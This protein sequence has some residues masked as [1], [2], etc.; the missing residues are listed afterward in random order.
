MTLQVAN[1]VSK[2]YRLNILG[3]VCYERNSFEA[4]QPLC[5][6]SL[7][8][9]PDVVCRVVRYRSLKEQFAG[10]SC[11]SDALRQALA[12]EDSMTNASLYILL[13]AADRFSSTHHRYPGCFDE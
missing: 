9:M 13:R 12:A 10:S 5:C 4:C 1:A 2:L 8:E 7:S 3:K 11:K 6:C